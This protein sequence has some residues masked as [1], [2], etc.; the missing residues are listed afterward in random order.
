MKVLILKPSSL[1]D[2]VHALPVAR[3]IRSH[4]PGALIDWFLNRELVPLLEGD[5]DL[6]RIVP[7]DRHGWTGPLGWPEAWGTLRSLQSERYDWVI[8]LQSLARTGIISWLTRGAFTIGLA[9]PREG[10]AA[11][12]DVAVPRPTPSTHAVDWYLE[13]LKPLG[14]PVHRRFQWL[15]VR[16]WAAAPIRALHRQPGVRWI[17]LQPGARWLNKRWPVEHFSELTRQLAADPSLR[18]AVFGSRADAGLAGPILAAAPGRV[19]DLCG[20]ISLPELIEWLRECSVLVTNDTGPMHLAAA[21]GTPIVAPFGPT[22][23]ERTGPYGQLDQTLRVSLPCAPC[24]KSTCRYSEP[25]ACLRRIEPSR[26]HARVRDRLLRA[27]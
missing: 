23:P 14:V 11:F 26:V 8:D 12:Y 18:I 13:V 5:P 16:E 15:P 19:L 7:F 4:H 21:V 9:D 2:V 22:A 27:A 20:R 1:G 3:L 6:R 17:G 25:L 10:A 24:L